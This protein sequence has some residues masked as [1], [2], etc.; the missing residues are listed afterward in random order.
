MRR[1]YNFKITQNIQRPFSN[2]NFQGNPN[3]IMSRTFY[4]SNTNI[5]NPNIEFT[6]SL[7]TGPSG[8]FKA[9]PNENLESAIIKFLKQQNLPVNKNKFKIALL[10]GNKLDLKKSIS[11]NNV[12]KMIIS[13]L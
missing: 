13:W 9:N 2:Y 12:K 10:G 7:T 6:I 3:K 4:N 1:K 11:K 8:R 5:F